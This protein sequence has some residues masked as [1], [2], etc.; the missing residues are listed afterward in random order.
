MDQAPTHP[1]DD[2]WGKL[3]GAASAAGQTLLWFF[4]IAVLILNLVLQR[5]NKHLK[6]VQ[7]TMV[8]KSLLTKDVPVEA[9]RNIKS[10]GGATL[11]GR[12]R[13][14]SLAS[15]QNMGTLVITFSPGCVHCLRNLSGWASLAGELKSRGWQIVWVSRDPS[16]VTLPYCQSHRISLS[17]VLADTNHRTFDLL[18]LTAVPNTIVIDQSG[19]VRQV[20]RGEINGESW[21]GVFAYFSIPAP[22]PFL[23]N[24]D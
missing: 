5:Q 7:S 6:E 2:F 17:D 4:A 3:K 24:G 22:R 20:W 13:E 10:I 16:G 1:E 14:V 23:A 11:D 12:F 8:P 18:G 21:R 19:T 9:G 15:D